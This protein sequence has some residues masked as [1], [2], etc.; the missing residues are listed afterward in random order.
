MLKQHVLIHLLVVGICGAYPYHSYH[1]VRQHILDDTG[2]LAEQKYSWDAHSRPI[3]FIDYSAMEYRNRKRD[4]IDCRR[5]IALEHPK[6][7]KST[8]TKCKLV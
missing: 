5:C 2:R 8:K 3:L 7:D 6:Q 4:L 1:S